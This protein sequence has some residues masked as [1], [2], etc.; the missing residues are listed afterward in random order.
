MLSGWKRPN[1]PVKLVKYLRKEKSISV[2]DLPVLYYLIVDLEKDLFGILEGIMQSKEFFPSPKNWANIF[3]SLDF[4]LQEQ[5]VYS[6]MEQKMNEDYPDMSINIS[7]NIFVRGRSFHWG[8]KLWIYLPD[9]THAFSSDGFS[10][11]H[12]KELSAL[13]TRSWDVK[14]VML[15]DVRDEI[16]PY[17]K[18]D[19]L[20]KKFWEALQLRPAPF[21]QQVLNNKYTISDFSDIPEWDSNLARL[22]AKLL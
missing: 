6:N 20:R 17:E 14:T 9:I 22:G 18:I 7:P 3:F 5:K 12:S 16:S 19:Y 4:P 10:L 11:S 13:L 1:T 2:S 15:V 8:E 21:S